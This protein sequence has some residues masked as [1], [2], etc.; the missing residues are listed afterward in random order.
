MAIEVHPTDEGIA[1]L[2]WQGQRVGLMRATVVDGVD[3]WE[4]QTDGGLFL[5]ALSVEAL[6]DDLTMRIQCKLRG[7][8]YNGVF[9]T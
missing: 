8:P 5:S 4:I 3:L 9:D 7:L 6:I 2:S 1:V